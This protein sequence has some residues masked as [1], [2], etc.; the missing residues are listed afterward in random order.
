MDLIGEDR[1]V[2]ERTPKLL[3]YLSSELDDNDLQTR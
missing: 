3:N 1:S 2:K